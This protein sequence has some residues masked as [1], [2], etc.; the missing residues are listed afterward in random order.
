MISLENKLGLDMK[1]EFSLLKKFQYM[2]I[3]KIRFIWRQT[4]LKMNGS[5]YDGNNFSCFMG[6]ENFDLSRWIKNQ[7]PTKMS[8]LF[9]MDATLEKGF[10]LDQINMNLEMVEEKLFNQGEFSVHGLFNYSDS[11]ISTISPAIFIVIQLFNDKWERD[12]RN[13]FIDI[14][15]DLEKADIE[16]V[17]NFLPGDF[18]SG[19]GTGR[20]NI[21]G[22]FDKPSVIAELYCEDIIINEFYLES[23]DLNSKIFIQ[24]SLVNGFTDIKSGKE[25]G[26]EDILIAEQCMVF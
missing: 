8:G 24:D 12:F 10:V 25:N 7:K 3:E 23:L 14:L 22:D 9:N 20:L 21:T 5:W 11:I 1:G 19:K 15:L 26:K 17:N 2:D 16:L 6:L 18:V 4:K 13:N